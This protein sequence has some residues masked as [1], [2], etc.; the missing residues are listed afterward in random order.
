[1][2]KVNLLGR[3]TKDIDLKYTQTN[4]KANI[5][6]QVAVNRNKDEVAFINC[7]AWEKCAENISKYF[8]KG[9]QIGITGHITTG[10]YDDKDGKK[11][12]TWAVVVDEFDFVDNK[13]ETNAPFEGQASDYI[14]DTSE[15]PF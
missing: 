12:Y 9:N 4:N 15:L 14:A 7:E 13:K 3:I 1:M 11:V 5:K 6:F 10:S 2:N 8:K